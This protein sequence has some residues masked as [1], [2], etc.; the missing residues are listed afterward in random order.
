MFAGDTFIASRS[1]TYIMGGEEECQK[2][3]NNGLAL[4]PTFNLPS[5]RTHTLSFS[6]SFPLFLSLSVSPFLFLSFFF[7]FYLLCSFGN[8][9][10]QLFKLRRKREEGK[11]ERRKGKERTCICVH[12]RIEHHSYFEHAMRIAKK[13]AASTACIT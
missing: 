8:Y 2:R 3:T 4:S 11:E 1:R 12:K 7:F 13:E 6:F 10:E 9:K 5:D